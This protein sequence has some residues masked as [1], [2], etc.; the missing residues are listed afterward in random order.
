MGAGVLLL[1][2]VSTWFISD[3]GESQ[4]VADS[5][6]F[7]RWESGIEFHLSSGGG[8]VLQGPKAVAAPN[9]QRPVPPL[10]LGLW[11]LLP[12]GRGHLGKIRVTWR[13]VPQA[14]ATCKPPARRLTGLARSADG[15]A[16]RT[17]P[18]P[19]GRTV[20]PPATNPLR[21]SLRR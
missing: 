2:E 5:G 10:F 1:F 16:E 3:A 15:A 4:R 6:T 12:L 13:A 14:T 21:P 9:L 20:Y 17:H 11:L 19:L 7:L 8:L 18:A